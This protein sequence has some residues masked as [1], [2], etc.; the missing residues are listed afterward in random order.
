[1]HYCVLKAHYSTFRENGIR[2]FYRIFICEQKEI[3]V[4][5]EENTCV[6]RRKF[7]YEEKKIH[8]QTEE[9]RVYSEKTP[10][11]SWFRFSEAA[12]QAG[13]YWYWCE[14]S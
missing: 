12:L 5:T 10:A 9:I 7:M 4:R 8:E 14:V 6:N 1:M 3:Q 11:G 13:V 2:E